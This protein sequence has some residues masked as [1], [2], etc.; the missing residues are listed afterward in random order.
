MS[1]WLGTIDNDW[2]KAGNWGPGGTGSGIPSATVDAIFDGTA[3]R[4]CVLGLNRTCRA[5]TFT[6]FAFQLDL[7]TF[8]LTTNNNITFQANQSSR[9]IGTTGILACNASGT[10]TSNSGIWP[11]NFIVNNVGATI[12]LADDMRVAGSWL[13]SGGGTVTLAGAFTLFI[14]TNITTNNSLASPITNVVMNGSG[15]YSGNNAYNL[16]INT[17]GS[18]TITGSVTFTRRFIITAA[19]SITMT[20]A[21]VSIVGGTTVNLGGRTI[22]TLS[23]TNSVG[24]TTI[25]TDIYCTSF[26]GL[27]GGHVVNG[28]GRIYVNG[29]YL[30]HNGGG[31]VNLEL[32]GSGSFNSFISTNLIINTSGTYT[33][34]GN[35]TCS[36]IVA[37]IITHSQGTI[38]P[39]TF[40]FQNNVSTLTFNINATGFNLY[41]WTLP[42][43]G[44][45]HTMTINSSSG[46]VLNILS[47][48]TILST[49]NVTF[50][51]NTGWICGGFIC[52]VAA[53]TITLQQAVTYR[54]R[55]GV[56]I[57]GGTA[58]VRVTMTSS[59]ASN[60]IWTLDFGAT[61]SLIYVNGTRID[62]SGGQ[63]VWSFGV[64]A[65]NVSTSINWNPGVPLRTVAYTFVN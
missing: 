17:T 34:T 36:G 30:G 48:L 60:A 65:A 20:A 62:S 13:G 28:P 63:T 11:L 61:Q 47:N 49:S 25:S 59:G 33:F 8:T 1:I 37:L 53:I 6:G 57:T 50:A 58:G 19:G 22:G 24:T 46:N 40:L 39:Q 45:V 26:A 42:N 23:F 14:G 43:T 3:T 31:N 4:N 55:T 51:G 10:I 27:G 2:N 12:T 9:I 15:T 38:N 44:L 29:P 18:I 7:A 32:I 54:T 52:S 56:S 64:S 35:V 41:D 21:N 5:L 16:E